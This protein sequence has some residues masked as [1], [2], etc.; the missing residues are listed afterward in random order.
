MILQTRQKF[1]SH[2]EEMTY[3]NV[4]PPEHNFTS[5]VSRINKTLQIKVS[6]SSLVKG[7]ECRIPDHEVA[8]SISGTST[9]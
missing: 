5:G 9:I 2:I 3:N 6:S 4:L 7:S 8:G 1:Y